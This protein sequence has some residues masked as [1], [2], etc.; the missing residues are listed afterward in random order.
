MSGLVKVKILGISGTPIKGGNCDVLVQEALQAAAA[1]GEVET[2]FLTLSDKK[3]E[4]CR[5]C[6]HCIEQKTKCI[7][8]DDMHLLYDAIEQAD[9][10]LVGGPTWVLNLSPPLVN[11]FTRFRY[12]TFFANMLRNKVVGGLTLSWFGEGMDHAL[13]AIDRWALLNNMIPV[14][15][16]GAYTSTVIQGKRADYLEHGV[17]D[18]VRG[19]S[20]AKNVAVRVVELARMIKYATE[21]GITLPPDR[22]RSAWGGK[23]K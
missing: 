10:M 5:H 8:Q 21:A 15:G 20:M 23:V 11:M 18:D 1:L 16:K 2:Q 17:L 22:M 19:I 3:I 6:Q 4:M 14:A 12:F 9:G 7:L 13:S